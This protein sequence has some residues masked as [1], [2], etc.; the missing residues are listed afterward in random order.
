[1]IGQLENYELERMWTDGVDES[2]GYY[3][4]ICMDGLGQ[5]IRY[6]AAYS[7]NS[8]ALLSSIYTHPT[9]RKIPTALGKTG[10][11]NSNRMYTQE[12]S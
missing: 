8:S 2:S 3:P 4:S 11:S 12:L 6:P 5:Y 9:Y 1:M 7:C 10:I